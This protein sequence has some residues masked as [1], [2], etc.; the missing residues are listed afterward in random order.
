MSFFDD[1]IGTIGRGLAQTAASELSDATG[2]DIG[3]TL[4]FLFGDGQNPG[5]SNMTD[6]SNKLNNP[7]D[8]FPVT[9]Q[10]LIYLQQSVEQQQQMIAG[11]GEQ[12]NAVYSVITIIDSEIKEMERELSKIVQQQLYQSWQ[13]ADLL[14]TESIISIQTAYQ[15]YSEYIANY[16]TTPPSEITELQQ[17]ILDANTGAAV[18]L[19]IIA[20]LMLDNGQEQGLLQLW[21]NMVSSLVSQ[22]IMDY[23]D[24]VNQYMAYYKKLTLAE[25]TAT[26]LLMEAYNLDGNTTECDIKYENYKEIILAQETTFIQWLMP[27]INAGVVGGF[28]ET[29][30]VYGLAATHACMQLNPNFYTLVNGVAYYSPS[31]ILMEAEKL[32]G[33]LYCTDDA[34]RRIVVHMSYFAQQPFAGLLQ[35]VDLTLTSCTN[36]NILT[37]IDTATLG[38][39][40]P[41]PNNYG[42]PD[43]NWDGLT[44]NYFVKRFVFSTGKGENNTLPDDSYQVTNINNQG[45]LVPMTTYATDGGVTPFM[46]NDVLAYTLTIDEASGFDFMNFLS[47]NCPYPASTIM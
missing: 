46:T 10:E 8:P 24:A 19:N 18:S 15:E 27:I 33:S 11:I 36:Q 44:L 45:Q 23:R 28:N 3:G 16:A 25:L 4:N 34:D 5:G 26:N 43:M 6:L 41:G 42:Y 7:V 9:P 39:F 2:F 17:N 30:V 38:A 20:G 35:A 47:Y 40:N 32:L 13:T 31:S 14:T 12:L 22:G 29:D 37:P 1:A 21:S